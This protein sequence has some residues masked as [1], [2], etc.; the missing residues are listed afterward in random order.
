MAFGAVLVAEVFD[1]LVGHL[2][3]LGDDDASRIVLV[4]HGSQPLEE[5]VGFRQ[6][7]AVR[8]L[9][10][11]KIGNG[12]GAEPVDALVQ[13]ELHD[14]EDGFLNLGVL[15]VEVRLVAEET[16]PEELPPHRVEGPVG[17][18][19]VDEDDPGVLVLLVG[20]APDVEVSVRP[21]GVA[22]GFLEP[23]VLV[24]GVVHGQVDDDPDA[25]C[26]GLGDEPLE[27]AQR[28]EF[29]EDV[30]VVGDVVAAV[31]QR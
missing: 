15:E 3:G 27:V 7:L 8:S 10:F 19:G 26:V 16:M 9:L 18:L 13:P 5:L 11:E 12:V 23:V 29:I 4:H 20:V 2:V 14:V 24:G 31:T 17:L 21:F 1:H 30:V 25:P 28:P 6:V 22:P